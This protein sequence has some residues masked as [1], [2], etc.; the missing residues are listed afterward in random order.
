TGNGVLFRVEGTSEA[1]ILQS[2][3]GGGN[4]SPRSQCNVRMAPRARAEQPDTRQGMSQRRRSDP[5]RSWPSSRCWPLHI[6]AQNYAY[7]EHGGLGNRPR[8]WCGLQMRQLVVG[9]PG[10]SFNL[11]RN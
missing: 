11:A 8:V 6:I 9:D 2:I 10:L 4:L 3:F 5:E 7:S 1:N